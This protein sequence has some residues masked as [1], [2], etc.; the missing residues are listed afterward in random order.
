MSTQTLNAAENPALANQLTSKMAQDTAPVK[1]RA[2]ITP[3]YDTVVNLP[4]GYVT[5]AGEVV[6][7]AEVRELNGKDEE[8]IARAGTMGKVLTTILSRG[9][10]RVGA[11]SATEEILD[12]MF[13]GDRD[14]LLLGIYKAT[15]GPTADVPTFCKGCSDYREIRVDVDEDIKV[16]KLS[17]PIADRKFTVK[18]KKAEYTVVLPSGKVQKELTINPDKNL[19]ELTTILLE[20]TVVE[21][22][23]SRVFSKAQIQEI[24]L[25]DRRVI[26]DALS[27]KTF[28]PVLEDVR[29][30][31]P[32]C[33]GEV[34]APINVG[35][36]FRF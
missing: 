28:G 10:V 7:E 17:D 25:A 3:P 18:G 9:T 2:L 24:G 20:G 31:C 5:F 30:T 21:I 32:D 4:G 27:K 33:G 11:E 19:A 34:V 23:G 6:T 8:A 1:E 22:N 35:T 12:Q 29:A 16:R 14:A 15:F 36:L 26:A 13:A